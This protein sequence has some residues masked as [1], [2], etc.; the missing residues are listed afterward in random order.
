MNPA[1]HPRARDRILETR[2]GRLRGADIDGLSVFF[3]VPYAAPPVGEGRFAPPQPPVP[4]AGVRDALLPGANAPQVIRAFPSLDLTPLVGRGW[5]RGEDFLT[6]NIWTPRLEPAAL[7]VLVF[8]HGGAFIG[9]ASDAAAY[10]GSAFARSGVVCVTINYRLGIEGFLPIPGAPANLGLRDQIAAIDWVKR[11]IGAFGG[12]PANVTVAGESAGAMS[13][14]NLMASLLAQGLFGRAIIQS[15][16]GSLVR[17]IEVASR[18]THWLARR[19]DVAADAAGFRRRSLEECVSALEAASRPDCPVDLRDASGFDPGLSRFLPVYGDEV[20]PVPPLQALAQGA[21]A[22]VTLLIGTMREEMNL[23]YVPTGLKR[24]MDEATALEMLG[25][26]VP[27]EREILKAYATGSDSSPGAAFVDAMTD[28]VFR[29]PVRRFA[30]AHKGRTHLYE[31]GWRSP[32]C[33]GELGACHALELPFVFDTLASCTGASGIA[34]SNPPQ[35]LAGE[36]HRLWVSFIADGR[37]PWAPYDPVRRTCMTL[38][39]GVAG[40]DGAIPCASLMS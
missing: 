40:R 32:A 19:L 22:D 9:G 2:Q 28:V 37:L 12:D 20:L 11:N 16:H 31:F 29:L 34:G 18:V 33:E 36:I 23:Y 8:I 4:W 21:G 26:I 39:S 5:R 7:P 1:G 15:G 13:I 27:R 35:A 17:P 38:D 25:A 30:S 24:T 10:D 14:A 3:G 6:L